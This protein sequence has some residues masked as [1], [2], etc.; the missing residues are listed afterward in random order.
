M[1]TKEY[2]DLSDRMVRTDTHGDHLTI[3]F[4]IVSNNLTAKQR[5]EIILHLSFYHDFFYQSGAYCFPASDNEQKLR[6]LLDKITSITDTW[7][8]DWINF[9]SNQYVQLSATK[10]L[11][12]VGRRE[13]L[14]TLAVL[15]GE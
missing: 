14:N 2:N 5:S 4:S 10:Q 1:R 6:D 11:G 12:Y 15:Y 7:Y 3:M 9:L 8:D 13:E